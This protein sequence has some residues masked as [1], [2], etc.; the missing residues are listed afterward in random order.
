MPAF[1]PHK[2][3][4]AELTSNQNG[5]TSASGTMGAILVAIGGFTFLI[6]TLCYLIF[7]IDIQDI[8]L[9]SIALCYAGATLLGYRKGKEA[10]EAIEAPLVE[11]PPI[12]EDRDM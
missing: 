1:N 12:E 4:L 6:S 10:Q 3:S 11:D 2:F 7:S 8:L 9:Q 5:K